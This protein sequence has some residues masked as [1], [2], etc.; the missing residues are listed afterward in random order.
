MK[1]VAERTIRELV[2]LG[3]TKPRAHEAVDH[4]GDQS[5][6]QLAINWLLDH[7]EEDKGGAVEFKHCPHV[8]LIPYEKLIAIDQ[9]QFGKPCLKGCKGDENWLCLMCGQ[10][11]CGRY[12]HRHSIQHWEE[13]KKEEETQ[14]TVAEAAAGSLCLGHCLTLGLADLS[15]WCYECESYVQHETLQPRVKRMEQ[16]K[17]GEDPVADVVQAC[18]QT[19]STRTP[20]TGALIPAKRQAAHGALGEESWPLPKVACVSADEARPGYKTMGASEYLDEPDVLRAKVKKLATLIRKSSSFVAYT[21]AGIS[22]S[23]GIRDYATKADGSLAGGQKKKSPFEAQPSFAHRSLVALHQ[24]GHLK[25]WVQQ[26][27]DGLPQKAGFPQSDLN[28]IHGAWYDPSNPVV[29]MDGTLR[30]DL[31]ER[32][33]D[34]EEKVDLCLALGT[35]MVGMNSDRMAVAPAE[36]RR[37]GQAGA[38]GTVIVAL[39]QTQYDS[40]ASIRIFATID[41]TMELLAEELGLTVPPHAE[42]LPWSEAPVWKGLPYNPNGERDPKC[43]M[44]LDLRPGRTLRVINQPKW[45]E[46]RYGDTCEVVQSS[47]IF[48]REGHIQVRFGQAGSSKSILRVLGRWWLQDAIDGK[49][50]VLPLVPAV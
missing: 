18:S 28:E 4:I 15:V 22:T 29:P 19:V 21:G 8:D 30:A 38:L 7:G 27:H 25:H 11:R 31:I 14:L 49:A 43:S 39:Q 40:L 37:R 45:D 1:T 50:D 44:T 41:Q 5:D 10:T 23:S 26:N 35:S 36:R 46:E 13:T 17:F 16:L 12:M 6:T 2:N 34:W 3:F 24:A 48:A 9:L 42:P 32:M 33:L 20:V 47:D